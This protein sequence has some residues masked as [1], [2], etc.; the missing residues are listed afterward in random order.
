MEDFGFERLAQSFDYALAQ[1]VF[2]HL[3]LNSIVR[4]LMNM[5]RVLVPGGRFFA[6]FYENEQGKRNLDD[7]QQTPRVVTHF[8]RDYYHYDFA[9][10]EWACEGTSLRAEYLGEWNNPQN[11]KMLV[12]V[13]T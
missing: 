6:T 2:T 1:S 7:I 9:T 10:F 3:H 5:E 11:Q 13:K 12:F 4:C 8:D